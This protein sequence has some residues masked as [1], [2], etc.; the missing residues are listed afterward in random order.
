MKKEINEDYISQLNHHTK[1]LFE[2]YNIAFKNKMWATTI[3]LSLTIIDNILYDVDNLDYVDGLD[4]NHFRSSK[5][6]HWLRIKRNQI[7]HF[8][9][10][11]EG[12]FGNKDSEKTL[13]LDAARANRTLKS[14]FYT[15]FRK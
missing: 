11:V 8:E 5:D 13:K 6:F 3:I 7:I 10:P 9:K 14:C 12:F 4:I 15:L 2:E 1:V